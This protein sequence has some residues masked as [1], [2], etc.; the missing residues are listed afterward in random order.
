MGEP[1]KLVI[2]EKVIEIIKRDNLVEKTAKVGKHLF[3]QLERLEQHYPKLVAN[4]RG[5]GNLCAFD[6]HDASKRDKLLGIALK[7]GL[8]IG[9]CGDNTVRFRPALIF[10]QKHADLSIEILEKSLKEL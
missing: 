4:V 5:A 8:H 6:L 2:L 9:G 1:T 10:E 3:D 7:N